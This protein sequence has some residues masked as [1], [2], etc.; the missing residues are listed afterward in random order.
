MPREIIEVKTD[1]NFKQAVPDPGPF[2]LIIIAFFF[3]LLI[4]YCVKRF[5]PR[6]HHWVIETGVYCGGSGSSIEADSALKL[7]KSGLLKVGDTVKINKGF[8]YI[9]IDTIPYEGSVWQYN[10]NINK[11]KN[12]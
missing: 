7:Y 1:D 9:T 12:K 6:N 2:L 5:T 3:G 11:N 4:A 8:Y 10:D